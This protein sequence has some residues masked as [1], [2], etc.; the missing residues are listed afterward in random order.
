MI[1]ELKNMS[2]NLLCLMLL[3]YIQN[4]KRKLDILVEAKESVFSW[5]L[6]NLS[7]CS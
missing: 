4:P 2:L 6:R 7:Y 5:I 3:P 1:F